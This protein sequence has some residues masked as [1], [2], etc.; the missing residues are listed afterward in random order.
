MN[1]CHKRI[2]FGLHSNYLRK[3]NHV[4]PRNKKK[5]DASQYFDKKG[6]QGIEDPAILKAFTL[7]IYKTMMLR[8]IRATYVYVCY[9]ELRGNMNELIILKK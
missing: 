7:N 2:Q 4:Q 9:E 5:N 6:K 3:R 1:S 8:G